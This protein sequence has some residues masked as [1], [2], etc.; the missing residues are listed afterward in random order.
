MAERTKEPE[1]RAGRERGARSVRPSGAL[2][3]LRRWWAGG[4]E[5]QPLAGTPGVWSGLGALTAV[6]RAA[7]SRLVTGHALAG[8][9]ELAGAQSGGPALALGLALGGVRVA[10]YLEGD[11]VARATAV[12]GEAVR[13]R[14]PLVVVAVDADLALVALAEAGAAVLVP[15]DVQET[16]DLALVARRVAEEELVPVVVALAGR[17]L[18]FALQSAR[19]ATPEALRDR[20]GSPADVVHAASTAQR[21]LLGE[22]RRRAPRWHDA[23]RPLRLGDEPSTLAAPAVDRSRR[24]FFADPLEARLDQAMSDVGADTGRPLVPLGGRPLGAGGA[25]IVAMGP[26]ARLAEAVVRAERGPGPRVDVIAVRRFA[27]FPTDTL[28][29]LLRANS[30]L[31]VLERESTVGAGGALGI[32]L[33]AA[34]AGT[35]CRP[36]LTRLLLAGAETPLR[37]EDLAW[38]SRRFVEGALPGC[39]VLGAA[40]ATSSGEDP[41]SQALFDELRRDYPALAQPGSSVPSAARFARP[42][43]RDPRARAP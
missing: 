10:L 21:V 16:A 24:V 28:A 15:G 23:G 13:R 8:R 18:A 19:M 26:D 39:F 42:G 22:H 20:L 4:R 33:R 3:K 31:A 25:G 32:T 34:L 9:E 7:D 43:Q 1:D 35:E 29:A 17:A 41:R 40:G 14:A 37:A 2:P 12:I 11:E 6:E 38:A 30:R 36:A 27:P 5:E